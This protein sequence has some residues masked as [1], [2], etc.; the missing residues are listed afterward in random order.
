MAEVG[1]LAYTAKNMARLFT[2]TVG[3]QMMVILYL[4]VSLWALRF[5]KS[6][7]SIRR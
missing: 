1:A 6:L 2:A 3:A 7:V 4:N 5:S